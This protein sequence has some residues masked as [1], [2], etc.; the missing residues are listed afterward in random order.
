M[1]KYYIVQL[2]NNCF[3]SDTEGDPG[4]VTKIENATRFKV[5]KAANNALK[6]AREFRPFK[7]AAILHYS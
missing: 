7:Q 3:V 1:K 2:E 6:R 4:R 5:W